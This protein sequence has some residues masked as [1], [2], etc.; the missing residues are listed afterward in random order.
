[1]AVGQTQRPPPARKFPVTGQVAG[2][3]QRRGAFTALWGNKPLRF[4]PGSAPG[5]ESAPTLSARLLLV[6]LR[7]QRTIG[8]RSAR[9]SK[10]R[11]RPKKHDEKRW[12]PSGGRR[13]PNASASGCNGVMRE[14][15][16]PTTIADGLYSPHTCHR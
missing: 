4:R 8:A 6:A 13:V 14:L 16:R 15:T 9:V 5:G 11:R 1:M 3:L 10:T 2:R 7:L 12:A